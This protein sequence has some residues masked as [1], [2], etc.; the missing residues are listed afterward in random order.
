[1]KKKTIEKH[2]RKVIDEFSESIED[3]ELAR[4]VR[5]N[6]IVTGGSIASMLM[7]EPIKDYDIYMKDRQTVIDL[8]EYYCEKAKEQRLCNMFVLHK[9]CK[10]VQ[11]ILKINFDEVLG[12]VNEY[13]KA[14][15]E[16]SESENMTYNTP[17]ETMLE[18]NVKS[19]VMAEG[20]KKIVNTIS[21]RNQYSLSW[22]LIDSIYQTFSNDIDRIKIF[23]SGSWGVNGEINNENEPVNERD[24]SV[25]L[26]VLD[27]EEL[28]NEFKPQF[29]SA[30]AITLTDKIQLVVR[31]Y[32]DAEE[33]HKNF[34]F[35]HAMCYWESESG[36]VTT[37]TEALESLIN[38]NLVYKGSK[39]PLASI[40]RARKFIYRGW[41]IDAGQ[42][43]KM[44]FQLNDLDLMDRY[45]LEEQLTGVDMMYFNS[46]I[47]DLNSRTQK[48]SSFN[49]STE[50]MIKIIERIFGQ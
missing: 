38:K 29:I 32:G 22:R 37:N 3:V 45:T 24:G 13:V 36:K 40:F 18:V 20:L 50:Y 31:F 7:N 4:K 9:D 30:N 48:D 11:D 35:V 6:A 2:L 46:I 27:D 34:D 49:P 33:L 44:A 25:E 10:V 17:L 43:L 28:K 26:D 14:S 5:K 16:D 12:A 42:Y 39:Y 21:A 15:K 1:M 8:S 41:S 19:G 23:S 47:A